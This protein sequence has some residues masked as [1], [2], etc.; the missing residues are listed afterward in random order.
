MYKLPVTTALIFFLVTAKS[1]AQDFSIESIQKTH[2]AILKTIYFDGRISP[3][4]FEVVS[5]DGYEFRAGD[6]LII[7]NPTGPILNNKAG[8]IYN[9]IRTV[10]PRANSDSPL[11]SF[12]AK[13]GHAIGSYINYPTPIIHLYEAEGRISGLIGV[14]AS[15]IEKY[16]YFIVYLD[17]AIL[18]KEVVLP[19]SPKSLSSENK[20]DRRD[21]ISFLK[22][23][24]DLLD[25]GILTEQEFQTE[26]KKILSEN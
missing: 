21:K 25:S 14:F 9:Y 1:I 17:D 18:S 22:E 20:I 13:D 3:L 12:T 16:Q 24:K 7:G 10:N 5:H 11:L 19:K 15:N 26:K 4:A 2:N 6:T 23:L 8:K